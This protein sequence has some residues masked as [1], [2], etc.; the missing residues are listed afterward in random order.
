MKIT[1]YGHSCL[2]VEDNGVS[3]IIDPFLSGNASSGITPEDIRVD[4]V[5]LTHAHDDHFGD[6]ISIAKRNDCPVIAVF[7]LANYCSSQGVKSEAVNIGGSREFNGFK[8][9]YT[10]AFHSSSISAGDSWIYAGQPAGVLLTMGGKTLYHAGDTSLFGDMRLIGE[11][12]SIDCAALPIGDSFTMGPDDALLAAQW[13]RTKKVIPVHY[14]T[15]PVIKQDPA[16]FC[17]RLSRTGVE[18]YPLKPGESIEL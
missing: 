15:F 16:A 9:K 2:L 17:E 6:T 7:E 3:V 10:Q 13:I 18:G 5:I 8:V 11:M 4:A 12:N 14:D 1:Y